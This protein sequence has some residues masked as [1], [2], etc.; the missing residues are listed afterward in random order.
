E[1]ADFQRMRAS[2]DEAIT[3]GVSKVLVIYTGGTIGMQNDKRHGYLPAKGYLPKKLRSIGRFHDPEGFSDFDFEFQRSNAVNRNASATAAAAAVDVDAAAAAR[4]PHRPHAAAAANTASL[5]ETARRRLR[6][7]ARG[8]RHSPRIPATT[9]EAPPATTKSNSNLQ[10]TNSTPVIP[11]LENDDDD[12]N[13][14]SSDHHQTPLPEHSRPASR[15]SDSDVEDIA[16]D[17]AALD[18]SNDPR[19]RATPSRL[20]EW[21]ITPRS[22]YGRRVQ[23][24]F[25]EYDPLLDSCNM[26]MTDWVRIVT[27]IERFYYTFDAFIILHGTDTMAYTASALSFMLQNL[28]KTVVVT[29]SQV[30][31]AEVR[32]DGIENFLGALTI[33]GHFVIPEVCLYFNNKLFRGNRCVKIDAMDFDAFSSPNLPPLVKVGVEIEVNWPE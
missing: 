28:G 20:S 13:H 29:G 26:D 15:V 23:Y 18:S 22:L 30:P 1:T 12:S 24:C 31:I 10:S 9:F 11:S 27:D 4:D 21:L 8:Q 32:N 7:M 14:S 16:R 17:L 19:G 33:A 6:D 3:Q 5:I 2:L 25:L